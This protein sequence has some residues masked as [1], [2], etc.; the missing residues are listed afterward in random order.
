[1]TI[2]RE[3]IRHYFLMAW[4][5]KQTTL[6]NFTVEFIRNFI[7][8]FIV[9]FIF[10]QWILLLS[11]QFSHSVMSDSFRTHGLQHTSPPCPSPTPGA[12][13]NPCPLSSWCHP[14]ISPSVIPF[15]SCLQSFP[16]SGS[17]Q[18]SQLFPSGGQSIGVSASA[19]V[20]PMIV[21]TDF[22]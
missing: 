11:V 16:G 7:E 6:E 20:L 15:S 17:F 10:L 13:S 19:S 3:G 12:Y 1:M 18:M 2:A 22:L 4:A 21:R 5:L 14:T 8:I 9:W